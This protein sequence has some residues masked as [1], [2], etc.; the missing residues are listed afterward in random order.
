MTNQTETTT[1]KLPSH[2]I[3]CTSQKPGT[4]ETKWLKVGAAWAQKGGKGLNIVIDHPVSKDGKYVM[5]KN[6]PQPK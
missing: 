1:K 3:Y 2:L 4:N 5:M 6:E